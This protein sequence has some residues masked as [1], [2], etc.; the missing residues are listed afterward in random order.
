METVPKTEIEQRIRRL[1]MIKSAYE[2]QQIKKAAAIL[3][4]G[5]AGS[6]ALDPREVTGNLKENF[7]EQTQ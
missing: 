7:D 3:H 1:R 6:I 4:I 5:F 2:V